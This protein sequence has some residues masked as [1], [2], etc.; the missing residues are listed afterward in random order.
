MSDLSKWYYH[1][2]QD[3]EETQATCMINLASTTRDWSTDRH[4]Q[5]RVSYA[6][7]HLS[8]TFDVNQRTEDEFLKD[9][10]SCWMIYTQ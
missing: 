4:K 7:N 10:S 1:L 2:Q 8:R 9:T 5:M 3:F 6:E